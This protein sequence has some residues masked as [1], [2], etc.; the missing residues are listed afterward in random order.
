[1]KRWIVQSLGVVGL[2]AAA[3]AQVSR[4]D[5]RVST[6]GV[7][8]SQSAS[9]LDSVAARVYVGYFITLEGASANA[10]ASLTFQPV[11]ENVRF[12]E[13]TVA[14]FAAVGNNKTGGAIDPRADYSAPGGFGRLKPW[15]AT[16]PT[17]SQSYVVHQHAGESGGAPS[18]QYYRIA[19]NDIS[20]WMGVGPTSGPA[21]V[22]NFNGAGG[23]ALVQKQNPT[24][25]DP[26]RVAG[27]SNLLLMVLALDLAPAAGSGQTIVA[28]A[29]VGGMSRNPA[30]GARAASW[31]AN[32]TEN[33]GSIVA[34]VSVS[35]AEIM[36]VI[37]APSS[38]ALIGGLC[39]LA[40]RRR[41]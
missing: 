13:D 37:P 2:A 20:R 16:G 17:T 24:G 15:A 26:A 6:D 31:Y 25:T 30:T 41:R 29:P 23:V 10:F 40:G 35:R 5:V 9:V 19:R 22:N 21:A 36:R 32:T 11:F 3:T 7:T 18:G 33:F 34:P 28:D 1:M 12:G 4:F 8:W 39:L 27:T 38:M 14:P